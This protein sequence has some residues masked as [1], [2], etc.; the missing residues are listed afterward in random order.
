MLV[1]GTPQ[2]VLDTLDLDAN[3]VQVPTGTTS[4]FPFP[5]FLAKVGAEFV[6]PVTDGF[7]ADLNP[8][9]EKQPFNIWVAEG[10]AMVEP[11]RVLDDALR[12]TMA[13]RLRVSRHGRPTYPNST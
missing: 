2:P 5:Q 8:P 13:V 9:L 6:A 7:M 1:H 10:E 4:W 11:D 12:Q 3:F